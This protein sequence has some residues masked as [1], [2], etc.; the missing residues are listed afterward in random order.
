MASS[1]DH[2]YRDINIRWQAKWQDSC[3]SISVPST[4]AHQGRVSSVQVEPPSQKR[5]SAK[6]SQRLMGQLGTSGL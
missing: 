2:G 5:K 6:A 4:T 3:N 1:I